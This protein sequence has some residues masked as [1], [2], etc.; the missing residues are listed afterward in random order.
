MVNGSLMKP[1][2]SFMRIAC[3]TVLSLCAATAVNSQPAAW[4]ATHPAYDTEISVIG[5]IHLLRESDYPLPDIV[6]TLY[7]RANKVIF[8]I[9]LDDINAAQMQSTLLRAA[10]LEND[11]ELKDIIDPALYSD[12]REQAQLYGIDIEL[13][14][15]FE[16]WFV[17]VSM[18]SFGM[19]NLGYRS[20]YGIEQYIL[21]QA[22]RD[23]KEVIG[24]ESLA[25]QVG[26]FDS[27]SAAEQAA[28]L[29]QTLQELGR[30]EEIMASMVDAWREGRLDELQGELLGEF[31]N[32]PELYTR[33]VVDRNTAWAGMLERL[34]T[35]GERY[36]MVVGAL[37]LVGEH[38]V[39]ELLRARGF[40]VTKVP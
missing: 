20:E 10:M 19:N 14:S 16:P 18:L 38:S 23:G 24:A 13:L 34:A 6:D 33:I 9:D 32:F 36:V 27:L 29:E 11:T 40:N 30:S 3:T 25:D 31:E 8:E 2:A 22:I 26:V 1:F 35:T 5:S 21:A 17:A 37:H 28:L 15:Q 7:A 39:I 4:R 12:A